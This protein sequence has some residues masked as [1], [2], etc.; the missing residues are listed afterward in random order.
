MLLYM[1]SKLFDALIIK[2]KLLFFSQIL[3]S[4]QGFIYNKL[5]Q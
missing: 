4:T 3:V 5:N 1:Q 2:N